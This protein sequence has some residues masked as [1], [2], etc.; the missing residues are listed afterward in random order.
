MGVCK[1]T[2]PPPL[3]HPHSLRYRSQA[4]LQPGSTMRDHRNCRV[5]KTC[6]SSASF[7]PSSRAT[8]CSD[9]LETVVLFLLA[10]T[11]H[12]VTLTVIQLLQRIPQRADCVN[13]LSWMQTDKISCS[14]HSGVGLLTLCD[15]VNSDSATTVYPVAYYCVSRGVETVS[16]HYLHCRLTRSAVAYS[17]VAACQHWVVLSTV[18]QLREYLPQRPDYEMSYV[19]YVSRS[20]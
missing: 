18:A 6:P 3:S 5:D 10:A 11:P 19:T 9:R 16:T 20:M 13:T 14:L 4:K 2:G 8:G 17:L 12:Y 7:Y 15:A 1:C